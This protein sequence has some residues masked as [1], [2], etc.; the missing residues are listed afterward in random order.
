M[1]LLKN[2]LNKHVRLLTILYGMCIVHHRYMR[3]YDVYRTFVSLL[4]SGIMQKMKHLLFI[5]PGRL[6]GST[7]EIHTK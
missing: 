5:M 4:L 3:E 2:A 6:Q 1:R 7:I